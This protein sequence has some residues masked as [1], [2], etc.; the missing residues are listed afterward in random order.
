MCA[1]CEVLLN[2]LSVLWK[3]FIFSRVATDLGGDG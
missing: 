3:V 2:Y 1:A